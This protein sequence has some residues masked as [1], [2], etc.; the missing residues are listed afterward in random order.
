VAEA[1][2]TA[3]IG[4]R[5][6]EP[7]ALDLD[8]RRAL[9]A[10][11]PRVLE[12]HRVAYAILRDPRRLLDHGKGD[13]DLWV[14]ASSI[15]AAVDL[16]EGAAT[17]DG[18]WILK[19]V[20]RP[21]VSSVYLYRPGPDPS[22]LTVDVFPSIRWL[23]A[24]LVPAAVLAASRERVGDA[25][26]ID[27]RTGALASCLHHLAW[28]GG[29]PTRY[30]EA[31]RRTL[32]RVDL[33][34]AALVD[35]WS[36]DPHP[37]WRTIRRRFLTSVVTRNLAQHPLRSTTRSAATLASLTRS[38]EGRWIAFAGPDADRYLAE[39]DRRLHEEHFLV[40]RWGSHGRIPVRTLTRARH[41]AKLV[42]ER[43]L[44]ALVLSSGD[45]GRFRP[46]LSIWTDGS[47]WRIAAP[48][49]P[50]SDRTVGHGSGAQEL[51]QSLVSWI[52]SGHRATPRRR[53]GGR[54]DG[55]VVGLVG[56][57]GSGKSTLAERLADD[58]SLQ[59]VVRYHWRPGVLP[60]LGALVGKQGPTGG[61]PGTTT[62]GRTLSALRLAYYWADT[63]LG[64]V[65]RLHRQRRAGGV[66]VLE[67]SFLDVAVDPVRYGFGLPRWVVELAARASFKPQLVLHLSLPSSEVVARKAELPPSEIERQDQRWRIF[68]PRLVDVRSLDAQQTPAALAV[69]ASEVIRR[70]RRRT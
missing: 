63:Q 14:R 30:L 26:T 51:F 41:L 17:D 29:V 33:P 62:R 20:R 50:G 55:I 54:P 23:F 8:A 52:A 60:R 44:G 28:N 18:W 1:Q 16:I 32:G 68:A 36:R 13:L 57:D 22:A 38:A 58:P 15:D 70:A 59:P 48:A 47:G 10:R 66:V 49:G 56:P 65:T 39:I 9:A 53:E 43:R 7:P 45:P 69:Q 42:F 64:F 67:R 24:D 6:R 19:R 37:R 5:D 31:Y 11:L 61:T 3:P 12:R 4:H 40:G 25:W 34:H 35:R 21:H 46:D 2:P 27:P